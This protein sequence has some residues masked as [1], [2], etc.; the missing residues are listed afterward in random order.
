MNAPSP[1]AL[2][3]VIPDEA[4]RA[5]GERRFDPGPR[6]RGRDSLHEIP[7]SLAFGS[8]SGMT[9]ASGESE[10]GWSQQ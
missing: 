8:A 5:Q 2:T 6:V 9:G 4:M 7:D 1:R 3:P 10:F